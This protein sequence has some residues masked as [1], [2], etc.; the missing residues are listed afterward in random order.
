MPSRFTSARSV[1]AMGGSPVSL[2][3]YVADVDAFFA[4]ALAAGA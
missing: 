2:Y 4:R 1:R 3:L